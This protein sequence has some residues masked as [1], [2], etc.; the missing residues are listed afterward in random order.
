MAVTIAVVMA[1]AG[2][3]P[4]A[5]SMVAVL[6]KELMV[7]AAVVVGWQLWLLMWLL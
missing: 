7:A 1:D 2:A 5:V 4:V 6:L 3:V